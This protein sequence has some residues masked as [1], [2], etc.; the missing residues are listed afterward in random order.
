MQKSGLRLAAALVLLAP[1]V[2]VAAQE[3]P[4]LAGR[5]FVAPRRAAEAG[6]PSDAFGGN[7]QES[8]IGANAFQTSGTAVWSYN[9]FLFYSITAGGTGVGPT[10][11]IT[12]D[13]GARVT[14]L[15]CTFNDTSATN[16]GVVGLW[17]STYNLVTNARASVPVA[18]VASTGSAGFQNPTAPTDFIFRYREGNER[19]IYWLQAAMPDDVLVSLGGCR[20]TWQRTVSA[21]PAV[22]TFPSDVP[23]GHPLLRFV[24]ALAAAGI[25]GG[26]APGSFCPD[27]PITRGQM[28]VFLS[29]ALGLHFPN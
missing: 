20:I 16:D 17:K 14:G 29:A 10:K 7:P 15:L 22:A 19:L 18:S 24:E 12:L 9:T 2:P 4:V 8:W 25:T 28:A 5:G 11:Q 27:S 26:C 1:A 6:E 13:P 23:V 21:P 3:D